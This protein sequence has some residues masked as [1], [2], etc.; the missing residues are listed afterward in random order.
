MIDEECK[1]NALVNYYSYSNNSIYEMCKGDLSLAN[2]AHMAVDFVRYIPAW[3]H[4]EI[5]DY[6]KGK[7]MLFFS[8]QN[9]YY[10]NADGLTDDDAVAFIIG[11]G[12]WESWICAD[13]ARIVSVK[14]DFGS[15]LLMYNNV[16]G[17]R[18]RKWGVFA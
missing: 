9:A 1:R 8:L 12:G 2:W 13:L 4:Y 14:Q 5:Q 7:Q 11:T 10:R 16:Y 18:R 17:R 3:T 6:N 15:F